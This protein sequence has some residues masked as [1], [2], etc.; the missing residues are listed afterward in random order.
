MQGLLRAM[1]SAAVAIAL[2]QFIV[3]AGDMKHFILPGPWRVATALYNNA[4]LIFQ[5]A[6]VTFGEVLL[7]LILGVL[8]GAASAIQLASSR[9]AQTILRPIMIFMQ[10]VPVFALAPVLTIWFGY[11]IWSKVVMALLI[12]YFPVMSAF[13]DGLKRTP[14]GYVDLARCMG[15]TPTRIMWYVRIPAAI[16]ALA[17]GLRLAAVYAP[18]GAVIGEWVGASQGLGHLMLLANGRAK[19][20]LMFAALLVLALFT[21]L[22]HI[23]VDRLAAHLTD[24]MS[25]ASA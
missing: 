17:S 7:G 6:L 24:R 13:Y 12:I 16:P 18:I 20:D 3:W 5:N 14:H 25:D 9:S 15:S 4:G 8:L 10:A 1:L 22:L 21:V 2:W 19:I 11:G 23:A